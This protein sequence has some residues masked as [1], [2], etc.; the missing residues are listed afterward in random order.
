MV[1]PICSLGSPQVRS[2]LNVFGFRVPNRWF[3]RFAAWVVLKSNHTPTRLD[4][5]F[6]TVGSPDSQLGLSPSQITP[7]RVWIR[8]SK[9]LVQPICSL[10]S[11][12]VRSPLNVFGFRVPNRWFTRFAAWVVP[13]LDHPST[14]LDSRFQTVGSP[15]LQLG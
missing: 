14:C 13:K 6:Q 7:Q 3:T 1:H 11:P 5:G 15:D 8:G 12:Q 4:S 9:P 2:P 10:G